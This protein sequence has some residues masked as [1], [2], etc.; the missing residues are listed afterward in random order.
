MTF[1]KISIQTELISE[2][3]KIIKSRKGYRSIAEFI[4][5]AIRLRIEELEKTKEASDENRY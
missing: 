5:E 4:S 3:E 1:R 2:V